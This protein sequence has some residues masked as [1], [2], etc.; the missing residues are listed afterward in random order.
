VKVERKTA[1]RVQPVEPTRAANTRRKPAK[2]LRDEGQALLTAYRA[3]DPAAVTRVA[4]VLRDLDRPVGL[5]RIYHVVAV[6][7]GYSTWEELIAAR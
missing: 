4:A 1:G 3:G 5:Q 7:A 2:A 6:E